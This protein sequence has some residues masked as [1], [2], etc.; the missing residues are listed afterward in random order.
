MSKAL[1][2]GLAARYSDDQFVMFTSIPKNDFEKYLENAVRY[3]SE[4]APIA[5]LLVK[6][7]V[8]KDV[9]K[10]I[11][12]SE[13]CDRAIMAMKSIQLNYEKNIAYYDDQLGQQHIREVMMENDFENALR[14]EEF[15]VRSEERR[16]GKECR[17][18]WSPYH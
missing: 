2:D 16:V 9:D 12:I 11:L 5:N 18:R 6:Y 1:T 8:Y 17:S 15:E 10:S 3:I 13:I 4:N 7:G 14:N